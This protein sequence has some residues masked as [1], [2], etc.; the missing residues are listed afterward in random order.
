M[1]EHTKGPWS[2]CHDHGWLGVESENQELYLKV[3]KGSTAKK[4]IADAR[5]IAAAPDLLD[6]LIDLFGAGMVTCMMGDGKDDQVEAIQKARN[7]I[8]KATVVY[9]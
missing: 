8:A 6:A 5:L 3:E 2:V 4:H 1:T 7:A 9:D